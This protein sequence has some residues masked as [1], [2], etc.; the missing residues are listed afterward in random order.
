MKNTVIYNP[1]AGM[2][3]GTVNGKVVSRCNTVRA[4]VRT[5]VHRYGAERITSTEVDIRKEVT[6]AKK[7]FAS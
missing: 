1:T 5:L 2:F 4:V 6:K 3:D 7:E